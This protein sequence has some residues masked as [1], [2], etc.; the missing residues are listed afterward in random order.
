MGGRAVSAVGR[1]GL[2]FVCFLS[3]GVAP[4]W[5]VYD[6]SS[7]LLFNCSYQCDCLIEASALHVATPH[8]ASTQIPAALSGRLAPAASPLHPHPSYLSSGSRCRSSLEASS[9]ISQRC[10]T[11]SVTPLPRFPS[12]SSASRYERQP[13]AT[14][15]CAVR[16]PTKR[17][18]MKLAARVLRFNAV[19]VDI[20]HGVACWAGTCEVRSEAGA[21][22]VKG[23]GW[24]RGW[25]ARARMRNMGRQVGRGGTEGLGE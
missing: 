16:G 24:R 7:L 11:L 17:T 25:V 19:A 14:S 15:P 18:R 23:G 22:K 8:G 4:S 10:R 6:L 20:V 12:S 3:H 2:T 9:S 5:L 1:R 21:G 13:C